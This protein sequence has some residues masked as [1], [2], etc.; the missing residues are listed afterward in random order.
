[1]DAIIKKENAKS[2]YLIVDKGGEFHC[3]HFKKTWC[4][5]LEI[6]PRF[7]AV[8]KHGS[9]AVV[10]RF[11][12]TF[13]ELVGLTTIPEE[14][15]EYE[16]EAQLIVDWYNE[17]RPHMTLDGK[18]PNEVFFSR[19]AA[20]EQPRFEPRKLWPRHLVQNH[21]SKLKDSQAIRFC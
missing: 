2:K 10:E 15:T 1:M 7:G 17:F 11:H 19:P 9:I 3:D 18:T 16:E 5:K 13:K 4:K 12:R 20:N 8:G 14:Q 6:K 21:K